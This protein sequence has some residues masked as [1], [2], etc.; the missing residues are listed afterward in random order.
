MSKIIKEFGGN[1]IK[2]VG[3]NEKRR[4]GEEV[5]ETGMERK[6]DWLRRWKK[7]LIEG[8]NDRLWNVHPWALRQRSIFATY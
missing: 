8:R 7:A 2:R 4:K 3:S 5:T 6:K 1:Q